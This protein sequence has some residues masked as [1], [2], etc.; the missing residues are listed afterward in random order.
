MPQRVR[1][2]CGH[3]H[4][5]GRFRRGR[6]QRHGLV[7][8][9]ICKFG[10]DKAGTGIQLL[11]NIHPPAVNHKCD[12]CRAAVGKRGDIVDLSR[13]IGIGLQDGAG[14]FSQIGEAEWTSAFEK[15]LTIHG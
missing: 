5:E 15:S 13:L 10:F 7:R 12:V 3:R 11:G 6:Y 1:I 2:K 14:E 8:Q 9:A 4:R